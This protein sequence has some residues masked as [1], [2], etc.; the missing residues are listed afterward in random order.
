MELLLTDLNIATM[1]GADYGVIE[2]GAIAIADGKIAWIGPQSDMPESA[3]TR[4]LGGRWITP[5]LIDCH[6]HLVFAGDRSGE[7]EERLGGATYEDIARAGGAPL[8]EAVRRIR[9]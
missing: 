5:A 6:T 8:V 1:A 4:S 2:D 7:F 9:A 3:T